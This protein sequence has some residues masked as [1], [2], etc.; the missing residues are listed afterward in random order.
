MAALLRDRRLL[1][2][3]GACAVHWGA[4]AP[5]HLMFGLFVRDAGLPSRV[6]GLS[7]FVAIGAEM[8]AL[9]VF[10]RIER[11]A[12]V[13]TM[14][15]ASFGA[16]ALRWLALA[17]ATGPVTVI[18]LQLVHGLTFGVFWG[19]AVAALSRLVPPPLRATGQALFAAVVFGAGN[20][21]G[22]WLSGLG[23]DALG[24]TRPLYLAAGVIEALLLVVTVAALAVGARIARKGC[25]NCPGAARQ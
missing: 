16:T 25:A 2:L 24:G 21:V 7:M 8:V 13:G 9:L 19:A 11:S 20:A 22:F 14:L 15:A 4:C 17:H 5:F 10:P 18:A 12:G 23:Y 6:T 1:A 3:L